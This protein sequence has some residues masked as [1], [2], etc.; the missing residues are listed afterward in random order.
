MTRASSLSASLVAPSAPLAD[1]FVT[2]EQVAV[3]ASTSLLQLATLYRLWY[4]ALLDGHSARL[5]RPAGCPVSFDGGEV[6]IWLDFYVWPSSMDLRFELSPSIGS[7]GPAEIVELPRERDII[8]ELTDRV[9]LDFLP[10]AEPVLGWQTPC[11][12]VDGSELPAQ[13][14]QCN[15]TVILLPQQLFGVARLVATAWGHRYRLTITIEK[16]D[17]RVELESPVITAAWRNAG[18]EYLTNQLELTVPEC[19]QTALGLCGGGRSHFC[20][21]RK[22][23]EDLPVN[24]YYSTCTGEILDIRA[25]DDPEGYCR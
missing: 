9:E 15:E 16:D 22:Q 21:A 13:V 14:L 25:G 3:P 19:V 12:A 7:I 8:V 4:R 18:G 6:T 11:F 10:V 5:Y 2:L 1:S 20:A 24:V 23:T 17:N